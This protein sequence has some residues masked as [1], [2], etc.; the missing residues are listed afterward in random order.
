MQIHLHNVGKRF[1]KQW[2][3]R[4]LNYTIEDNE[5]VAITGTNGSGKSTLLKIISSYIDPTVGSV[6]YHIKH[7]PI[8]L[9]EVS[10]KITFCAPYVKLIEELSLEE[11]LNFHFRFKKSLDSIPNICKRAGLSDALHK[12]ILEF[13]SGMKQRL[14][15]ALSL[16]SE[17]ELILL[18]EPTAN[19]DESGIA[20][21]LKEINS[22]LHKKTI[23]IA[24]NQ[25]YEYEF[26]QNEI[27]ILNYKS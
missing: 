8:L 25:R 27:N 23:I 5:C 26:T 7:S 2:I 13:S 24:S 9:E 6:E 17:N 21:Y 16:F 18:D 10:T 22:L 19:M 14:K 12:P 4:N 3:F 15:L 11:H 20:W 1:N